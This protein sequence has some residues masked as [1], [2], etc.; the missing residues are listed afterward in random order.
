[1]TMPSLPACAAFS[2]FSS[3]RGGRE[4]QDLVGADVD[5]DDVALAVE[6]DAVRLPQRRTLHEHRGGPV[7]RDLPHLPRRRIGRLAA[8]ARHRGVDGA[9]VGDF[10]VVEPL[11]LVDL[12]LAR[13]RAR[14][15]V[16]LADDGHARIVRRRAAVAIG[17]V[18]HALGDVAAVGLVEDQR[19]RQRGAVGRVLHADPPRGV[20]RA[21]VI[22]EGD[23]GVV[24]LHVLRHAAVRDHD[25][26]A[27]GVVRAALGRIDR[28]EHLH[29]RRHRIER[30]VRRRVDGQAEP[31]ADEVRLRRGR[32]LLRHQHAGGEADQEGCR[33]GG[34]DVSRHPASIVAAQPAVQ[35]GR[36]PRS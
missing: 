28:A 15:H 21:V 29:A 32:R 24:G 17:D 27:L 7:R 19:R 5:D 12:D 13:R 26:A 18:E 2:V 30:A 11:H 1:M 20:H 10:D 8:H 34:Y 14:L 16:E 36:T 4:R 25:H 31:V 35:R 9:V 22:D 3:L 23:P 6:G 33:R